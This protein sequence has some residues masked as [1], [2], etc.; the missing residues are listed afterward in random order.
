MVDLVGKKYGSLRNLKA[1]GQVF[2]G[3]SGEVGHN[4]AMGRMISVIDKNLDAFACKTT[5]K[6]RP[7]RCLCAIR[8]KL[9][10]DIGGPLFTYILELLPIMQLNSYFHINMAVQCG[11]YS[12]IFEQNANQML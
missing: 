5:G 7:K 10:V 4:M 6:H 8:Y 1:N 3:E 12:S 9:V 2:P 11:L